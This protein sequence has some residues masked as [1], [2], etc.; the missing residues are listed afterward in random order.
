MNQPIQP[1]GSPIERREKDRP[2]ALRIGK[3]VGAHG[4]QGALK[5]RPTSTE[6]DWLGHLSHVFLVRPD[7]SQQEYAVRQARLSGN[8]DAETV[9]EH[10][11]LRVPAFRP[12][13]SLKA[14]TQWPRLARMPSMCSTASCSTR[15]D[16]P[17]RVLPA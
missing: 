2:A 5:I 10:D 7:H 8:A 15:A 16:C 13:S 12:C 3:V 14:A 4:L 1:S 11:R 9:D 6:P 17:H